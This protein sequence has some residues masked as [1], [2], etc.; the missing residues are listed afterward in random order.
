MIYNKPSITVEEE[1]Q[2]A[3]SHQPIPEPPRPPKPAG[4]V[5]PL[6][7]LKHVVGKPADVPTGARGAGDP[8][9]RAHRG[10]VPHCTQG[11]AP[12][13]LSGVRKGA[14]HPVC[15]LGWWG[16]VKAG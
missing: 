11:A 9:V 3:A 5:A 13:R 16:G 2:G 6:T 7:V 15:E 10:R 12:G 4:A 1:S 14:P 8:H